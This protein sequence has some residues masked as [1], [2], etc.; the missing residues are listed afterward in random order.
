M[1]R[2]GPS[3]PWRGRARGPPNTPYIHSPDVPLSAKLPRCSKRTAC[4]RLNA[5][6]PRSGGRPGLPLPL[7]FSFVANRSLERLTP[8]PSRRRGPANLATPIAF[9]TSATVCP[10]ASF[11]THGWRCQA[12]LPSTCS[13]ATVAS[14]S[15]PSSEAATPPAPIPL[16]EPLLTRGRVSKPI[17]T[18]PKRAG[19]RREKR[20]NEATDDR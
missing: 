6:R 18:Q 3:V 11:P 9:P 13:P 17:L 1:H 19:R 16:A 5:S 4:L 15:V 12:C 7:P 10:S 8:R 20:V 14:P 2:Y